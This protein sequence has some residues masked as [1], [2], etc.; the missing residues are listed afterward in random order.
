[1]GDRKLIHLERVQTANKIFEL[2]VKDGSKFKVSGD[3]LWFSWRDCGNEIVRQWQTQA[4]SDSFPVF[5]NKWAHGGT[6]CNAL[7]QLARWS[8]GRNV[9]PLSIWQH[10]LGDTVKL[11][12]DGNREKILE[13]LNENWPHDVDCIK[14]GQKIVGR[15]DWF[16]S[17]EK[18]GCGHVEC[19]N[20]AKT[21][22]P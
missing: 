3:R 4:R 13:L 21:P 16:G 6:H 19:T 1:M 7:C 8:Q 20:Q 5:G 22:E 18:S 10:W 17:G 2:M 15:Y 11:G 14:C 9:H 12:I